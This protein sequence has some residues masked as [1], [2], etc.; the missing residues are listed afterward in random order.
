MTGPPTPPLTTAAEM[1][2]AN[3]TVTPIPT[4][5]APPVSI[6]AP[7]ASAPA[8]APPPKQIVQNS[9]QTL[10]PTLANLAH[11][12][13]YLQLISAAEFGDLKVCT[14]SRPGWDRIIIAKPLT[15]LG[16]R[17]TMI[18]MSPDCF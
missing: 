6:P 13:N 4:E 9:Y 16:F 10:F 14:R 5:T 1:A 17:R 18:D 12:G 11:Q 8:P 3:K 15:R 2:D 7:A